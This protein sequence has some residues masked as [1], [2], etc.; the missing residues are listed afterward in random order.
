VAGTASTIAS[1]RQTGGSPSLVL[2]ERKLLLFATDLGGVSA[3]MVLAVDSLH[4]LQ[5]DWLRWEAVLAAVWL[6]CSAALD[7]YDLRYC[8]RAARGVLAGYRP[9]L[10]TFVIYLAIPYAT[11]PLLSSRLSVLIW[12][13]TSLLLVGLGRLAYA[14]LLT[15]P[16]FRRRAIIVGD[17][18]AAD[19]LARALTAEAATDY[20]LLGWVPAGDATAAAPSLLRS[21]TGESDL[22]TLVRSLQASE[23]I[24][25]G[26]G[27]VPADLGSAIVDLYNDGIEVTQ[28][29][30]LYEQLVGRIPV[31]HVPDHWYAAL[32]RRAGGGR[33]YDVLRRAVDVLIAG[34]ALVLALPI[35]LALAALIRLEGRG[36]VL[37]RQQRLGHLGRSFDIWK[38]RTMRVGS[39]RD[40][41]E[42]WAVRADPR[43]TRV[44]RFLRP[45]RLDE[46]PQLW[47]VL[48][49]DMTLIGPRPERPGF[50]RSLQQRIPFYRSR[51]LVKP[52][53]TGWAQVKAHYASNI[54]AS[55][56]KLQYDLYYVKHRSP[57]LDLV[58]ALKSLGV[59]L[60]ASGT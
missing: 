51:L 14:R 40:G 35:L 50:T 6:V 15:R 5:P 27:A 19:E 18:T 7:A 42:V 43:R 23:V 38:F 3:A 33:A 56:E 39:E 34:A 11:A 13:T 26:Q 30:D 37:Y 22:V 20:A 12:I 44:G 25:A 59:L 41:D 2:G 4:L 8:S 9:L 49:G 21:L 52:G 24:V 55:L 28:M 57:Y 53:L 17:A 1:Q 10:A 47:N 45:T 31:A 58:I 36:P 16:Q 29:G 54:D 32:P 60:R 48:L 46:L